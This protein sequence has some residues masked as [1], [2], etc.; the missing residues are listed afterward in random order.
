VTARVLLF[1][2]SGFLGKQVDRVLSADPRVDTLIRAGRGQ[3]E[4]QGW[5]RHDLVG[6]GVDTLRALVR[7]VRPDAVVN[8]A[9]RLAGSTVELV[10]AN[11]TVTARLLDAVEAEAP[12][13]RLVV[14]GSAAEYGPVPPDRAVGEHDPATPVSAYGVTRL[15]GTQL[16]RVAAESGRLDAVA[17]RVFNPIGPGLPEENVLGRAARR[18]RVALDDGRDE[19]ELGPLGARRDFV[20]VRDVAAAIGAAALA[21]QV[22]EPVVN[23][24]SGH[25]VLVRAAVETLA[26]V[27]GF[28]GRIVESSAAPARSATVPWIA[29]DLVR[30]QRCLGWSPRHDLLSS[31]RACWA[32]L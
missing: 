10:E 3:N 12:A 17:L 21:V 22:K 32:S 2:A 30:A 4:G 31:V 15:A 6:D 27:A 5:V 28:P 29:A 18:I 20:D 19:I 7:E 26:E 13:A 1:G 25:A 8:C 24:G 16:V 14:L 11:V 23:V 9:G